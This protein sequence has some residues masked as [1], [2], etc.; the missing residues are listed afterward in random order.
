MQRMLLAVPTAGPL[1]G[2]TSANAHHEGDQITRTPPPSRE[3]TVRCYPLWM[4]P[5]G[6]VFAFGAEVKSWQLT[7]A[8]HRRGATRRNTDQFRRSLERIW[9]QEQRSSAL[10]GR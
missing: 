4:L 6:T 2:P 3:Q 10:I 5:P 1:F 8:R 7:S 9:P